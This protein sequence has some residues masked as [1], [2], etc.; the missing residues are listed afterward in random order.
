MIAHFHPEARYVHQ[1]DPVPAKPANG[2]VRPAAQYRSQ[3]LSRAVPHT[4][5]QGIPL[6]GVS[7]S[8]HPRF[9]RTGRLY[10]CHA[11][12]HQ[13]T[14]VSGTLLEGTKLLL[15]TWFLATYLLT[16]ARINLFAFELKRHL[17]AGVIAQLG[18]FKHKIMQAM[19]EREEPC[20]LRGSCRWMILTWV[21]SA[22]GD[23]GA[24]VVRPANNPLPHRRCHRGEPRIPHPCRY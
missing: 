7:E 19:V 14:L 1:P 5:A 12:Q 9:H 6:S 16:S 15:I 23:R 21:V 8:F 4:L 13:A 10:Q 11:C 2:P 22:N 3:E 24:V 17:G 20:Q 18:N